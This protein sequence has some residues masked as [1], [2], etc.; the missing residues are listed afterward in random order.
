MQQLVKKKS[1]NAPAG[2]NK[3]AFI[4][5]IKT[6]RRRMKKEKIVYYLIDESI[7]MQN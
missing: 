6:T 2:Y 4:A 7:F 3:R 5:F 1:P